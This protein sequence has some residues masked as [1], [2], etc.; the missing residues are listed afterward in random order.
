MRSLTRVHPYLNHFPRTKILLY[1]ST[2]TIDHRYS[3]TEN[4]NER[5][6]EKGAGIEIEFYENE[7]VIFNEIFPKN[8]GKNVSI[9]I[10]LGNRS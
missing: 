10:L 2:F 4:N 7:S 6:S 1:V 8:Y 5:S 9:I 3:F